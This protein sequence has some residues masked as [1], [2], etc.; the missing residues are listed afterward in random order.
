MKNTR[1]LENDREGL[2]GAACWGSTPISLEG[3][4]EHDFG[5]K[6]KER[7]GSIE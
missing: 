5:P 3:R 6:V 7:W 4:E 1:A 2:G